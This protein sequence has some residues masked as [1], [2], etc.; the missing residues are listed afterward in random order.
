MRD[1]LCNESTL[2]TAIEANE[3]I[4]LQR[5]SK[6]EQLEEDIKN[7]IQ[8]Y[9]RKNE[10]II[11]DTKA[12]ILRKL[13]DVMR[14]KYS[15]GAACEEMEELYSRALVYLR[16]LKYDQVHYISTLW[17]LAFGILLEV[18]KKDFKI[19][20]DMIDEAKVDDILCDYLVNAYGMKRTYTSAGFEKKRPYEDTQMIWELA[21]SE[22]ALA[23][24]KL[25]EYVQKNWLKGHVDYGWTKAHKE[26]GYYGLWSVEAAALAKIL[27]IDDS[28]LKE[29]NHYPYDLAHYKN[30]MKFKQEFDVVLATAEEVVYEV[31]IP[32]NVQLE[33]IVPPKFHKNIQQLIVDYESLEDEAFWNKY[34]LD[35][36]WYNVEEY[37][38][39][40]AS[41]DILG[42]L[43]I[44]CLVESGYILQL[45]YKED[46]EDYVD[47][48][49][50][51]WN[52]REIKVVYFE[53]DNDQ[54]YLAKVPAKCSLTY[55]YEVVVTEK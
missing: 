47:N 7:G 9:P 53:L 55:V 6:I 22:P 41:G 34:K 45:D 25:E 2:K 40:K 1:N 31:G 42:M 39:E 51:Y 23:T 46:V 28:K 4:I 44:D 54:Q 19:L 11:P 29:D 24:V 37:K 52:D 26:A 12:G 49:E 21:A 18:S 3:K 35:E 32:A 5:I 43:I 20:I 16:D 27:G 14:A 48:L 13:E 50:N 17:F 15:L 30:S 36:L 8:R 38:T 33:Q 10:E